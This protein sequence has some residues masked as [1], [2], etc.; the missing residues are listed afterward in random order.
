MEAKTITKMHSNHSPCTQPCHRPINNYGSRARER[1]FVLHTINRFCAAMSGIAFRS[2]WGFVDFPLVSCTWK[3]SNTQ[4]D[5]DR[6]RER[7]NDCY[8]MTSHIIPDKI[9]S[10]I[11]DGHCV[12]K[13]RESLALPHSPHS[14]HTHTHTPRARERER[15]S[16]CTHVSATHKQKCVCC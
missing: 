11:N 6:E 15:E 16:K 13:V 5:R 10:T 3:R 2:K 14:L 9:V 12:H 1:H 8:T 7:E 4:R